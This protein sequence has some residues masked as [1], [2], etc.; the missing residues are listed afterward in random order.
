[1]AISI[2]LSGPVSFVRLVYCYFGRGSRTPVECLSCKSISG[3]KRI[4]PGP[5]IYEGR[6]WLVEHAYPCAM[7]GWLVLVLRRHAEALHELTHEELWELGELQGRVAR[8]LKQEMDVEKEYSV[9]FG[10][11]EGFKH[12]HFHLIAKP[13]DLPDDLKGARIFAMLKPGEREPAPEAEIAEFCAMLRD[14]MK[15]KGG[16]Q[17]NG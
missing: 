5:I 17:V 13:R 4:S 2:T 10:E 14:K 3:Q 1:M 11:V 16:E 9:C 15:S 8:L 12:I 6:S 7:K